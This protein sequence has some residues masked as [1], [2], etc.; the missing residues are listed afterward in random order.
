MLTS[1]PHKPSPSQSIKQCR[2]AL[3]QV[4][5]WRADLRR[6]SVCMPALQR[7]CL[8]GLTVRSARHSW[9]IPA[10]ARAPYSTI[11]MLPATCLLRLPLQPR[12]APPRASPA[13]LADGICGYRATRGNYCMAQSLSGLY[14]RCIFWLRRIGRRVS[15]IVGSGGTAPAAGVTI[16][17]AAASLLLGLLL[18]VAERWIACA[19]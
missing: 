2:A 9:C 19:G 12:S 18:I 16:A 11:A 10:T 6:Q 13:A 14:K 1:T 8:N 5:G 17:L 7:R 3:A 4:F 15:A